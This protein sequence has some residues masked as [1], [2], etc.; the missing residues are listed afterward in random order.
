MTS[1]ALT[2]TAALLVALSSAA[3]AR[4]QASAAEEDGCAGAIERWQAFAAQENQGGH[5]DTPVFEAI[6]ADIGRADASCQAGHEAEAL[7][8][9]TASKRR[10]GY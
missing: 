3:P 10:H 2:L 1:P 6:Q 8:L 4:A 9:V 5:M 7:R